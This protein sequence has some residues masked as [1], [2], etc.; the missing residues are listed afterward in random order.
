MGGRPECP[1]CAS[2]P[3]APQNKH[4]VLE[5]NDAKL[6]RFMLKHGYAGPKY[7]N[8][9]HAVFRL[10]VINQKVKGCSRQQPCDFCCNVLANFDCPTHQ[11]W[12]R[13]SPSADALTSRRRNAFSLGQAVAPFMLPR[14]GRLIDEGHHQPA[15]KRARYAAAFA[16]LGMA[17][18]LAVVILSR[19][20]GTA[21]SE[22]THGERFCPAEMWMSDGPESLGGNRCKRC[23]QCPEEEWAACSPKADAACLHWQ[24]DWAAGR[25]ISDQPVFQQNKHSVALFVDADRVSRPLTWT[26]D[27]E[28]KLY[29]L[30]GEY[31]DDHS[32]HVFAFE[33]TTLWVFERQKHVS[34]AGTGSGFL[35]LKHVPFFSKTAPFLAV[36]G[37]DVAESA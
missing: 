18:L 33:Y 10:H 2:R 16:V 17:A 36:S 22:E 7:C 19:A 9:C 30:C 34:T 3:R 12:A 35:L 23:T 20:M 37:L 6:N 26:S 32:K 1:F 11:L 14:S 15:A 8:R 4:K 13:L 5:T 28:S 27:D 31:L 21:T 24:Q 25:G 29:L